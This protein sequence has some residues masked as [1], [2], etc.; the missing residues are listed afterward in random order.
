MCRLLVALT[1][2][3]DPGVAVALAL[4]TK[5]LEKSMGGDGN[6][7]FSPTYAAPKKSFFLED[8]WDVI[9]SP[10]MF[11]TRLATGLNKTEANMHPFDYK[12]IILMHNGIA[13]KY[14]Q[15]KENADT[16]NLLHAWLDKP[17]V[18]L[19]EHTWDG[20]IIT[21]NKD[22]QQ[23]D[24]YIK[25][26]VTKADLVDG[27]TIITSELTPAI[28]PFVTKQLRLADGH[29]IGN[30][31]NKELT[32]V[33]TVRR[34]KFVPLIEPKPLLD[35]KAPIFYDTNPEESKEASKTPSDVKI[36][37]NISITDNDEVRI[38]EDVQFPMYEKTSDD[39][40]A[41]ILSRSAI[42]LGYKDTE[43]RKSRRNWSM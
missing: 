12:N 2:V 9:E 18:K 22:N 11:H 14:A 25:N 20:N 41:S 13:R 40:F 7:I 29:W 27:T 16:L 21:Y 39:E 34:A 32:K 15:P 37:A 23:L 8:L 28:R 24:F 36:H 3:K 19:T 38:S 1:E 6:G 43:H 26:Y 17:E 10:F 5:E 30:F 42:N 4:H 31:G 33:E 35:S